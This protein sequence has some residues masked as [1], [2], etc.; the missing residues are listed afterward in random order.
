MSNHNTPRIGYARV[1]GR[2]TPRLVARLNDGTERSVPEEVTA[3]ALTALIEA[4]QGLDPAALSRIIDAIDV[5]MAAQEEPGAGAVSAPRESSPSSPRGNAIPKDLTPQD[6]ATLYALAEQEWAT[7]PRTG[8][9]TAMVE[10]MVMAVPFGEAEDANHDIRGP[11][12]RSRSGYDERTKA[13]HRRLQ[14]MEAPPTIEPRKAHVYSVGKDGTL[15]APS[16]IPAKD[17]A[18]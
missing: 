8:P 17:G 5:D 14:V 15:E 18:K 13:A 11:A 16:T 12:P 1:P 4:A 9:A 7:P 10:Q 3:D 2:K 6:I